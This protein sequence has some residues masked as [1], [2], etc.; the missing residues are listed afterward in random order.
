MTYW[1]RFKRKNPTLWH[2]DPRVVSRD[3]ESVGNL[4][5]DFSDLRHLAEQDDAFTRLVLTAP[6]EALSDE[7]AER[8]RDFKA[9][10]Y[11]D[12][13]SV[14][15]QI[16]D[17]QFPEVFRKYM[18]FT[19]LRDPVAHLIKELAGETLPWHYDTFVGYMATRGI[20]DD[21]LIARYLVFLEDWTWGQYFFCGNS[22]VHQWRKG[23]IFHLPYRMHHG[24]C[25]VGMAPKLT[26]VVTGLITSD[27]LHVKP[28]DVYALPEQSE[29]NDEIAADAG[30]VRYAGRSK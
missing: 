21:R 17:H 15:R 7:V 14:T 6:A 1:E 24:S 13:T 30:M 25:N 20:A 10:G 22:V 2:F 5:A 9:W 3:C 16:Y 18:A 4:S 28:A 29:G 19:K 27:A 8:I 12:H 11:T 26:L 23:D